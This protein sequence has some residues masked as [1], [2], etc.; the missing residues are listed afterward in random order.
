MNVYGEE[1]GSVDML[2]KARNVQMTCRGNNTWK[3]ERINFKDLRG[4]KRSSVSYRGYE[5]KKSRNNPR[6]RVIRG[7]MYARKN[8]DQ[9][10]CLKSQE[11]SKCHAGKTISEVRKGQF[12]GN[13]HPYL[14]SLFSFILSVDFIRTK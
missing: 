3:L 5:E 6:E 12:W 4:R 7:R 1:S 8:Q 9:Y 13:A 10:I 2:E 14:D 11:I